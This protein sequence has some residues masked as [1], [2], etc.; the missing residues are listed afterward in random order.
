M[1]SRLQRV[2]LSLILALP[3]SLYAGDYT[4]QE[5]TQLTGGSMLHMIKSVGMFSSQ[6]RKAGDPVV[7][8]IYIK[9]NRIAKVYADT[10]EIIDLDKET[11]TKIDTLKQTY[12]VMT[13][14]QISG[15]WRRPRGDAEAGRPA[16]GTADSRSQKADVKM[17]FDVKVRNTGVEKADQ[18]PAVATNPS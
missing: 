18:R 6:A 12:T 8:T 10:I 3:A 14:E 2:L 17:S 13:F 7:S 11:I 15:Q 4:Y 1:P 9:G 16:A 5:T